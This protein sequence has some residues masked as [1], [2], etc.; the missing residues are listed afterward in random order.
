MARRS[1][2]LWIAVLTV[3][4]ACCCAGAAGAAQF[5][6]IAPALGIP[7]A[8]GAA[9]GDY[10]G[11]GYADLFLTGNLNLGHGAHLLRN[12]GNLSFT[13]VS[14]AVGIPT[15]LMDQISCAWADYDNDG[16]PDIY[17]GSDGPLPDA[18]YHNDGGSFTDVAVQAG[19]TA[20]LVSG[21]AN[22]TAAWCDY[23]GDGQL[24]L[25]ACA[26]DARLLHN[27][28]DG[29]FTDATSSAG[30]TGDAQPA[31]AHSCAWGDYDNDGRPDL[32]VTRPEPWKPL[33]YHNNGDGT[34]TDVGGFLSVVSNG[35]GMAWGD[36]DNDGCLDLY[37]TTGADGATDWLFHNNGDGTF[38]DVAASAGMGAD[39][40]TSDTVTWADY[41]NDGYLDI[42]V[43][44]TQTGGES[45]LY[46]NN[47][48]GTFTNVAHD[49]GM[50]G[51]Y[52]DEAA[53]WADIDHDGRIDLCQAG[54]LIS[55]LFHNIG[56]AGN[57]LRVQALT[58]GS[59]DATGAD[60]VRDAIGAR[61]EVNL[62]DDD[63][64]AAGRILTRLIDGGSG[65][66]GQ[67]EQI[68]Q[69]GLGTSTVVAVRVRFSDGSMVVHRSVPANQ[70]IVVRDVPAGRVEIFDDVPLDYWAYPSIAAA[71]NAHI[72]RGYDDGTYR[73]A[74][75]VDRA[76]MAVYIARALAGG[77]AAVPDPSEDTPTFADAGTD[78]WA[79]KYIEY[80]A[81]PAANVVQGYSDGSYQPEVIVNRGQMAVYIARA[82]VS[83]SGDAAVP[84][85]PADPTFSDVTAE[86][87]WS[88][89]RKHVE[90]LAAEG[91]VQGYSDGTYHPE[92][93]ITR[94]QMAVYIQRA[95][96]LPL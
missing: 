1:P 12:N 10:D 93:A 30:L 75:Q 80:V 43:G 71:V 73:P 49:E 39:V 89:C 40:S 38:T 34:F 47:G 9:W 63:G 20:I 42:Y 33:L 88:W 78:H 17:V 84:D 62:D 41:D 58:S 35:V 3:A 91:I 29:T 48:D 87:D 27:N 56:P 19:I 90:Y 86:N 28:G 54:Q 44:N 23:D 6:D 46:H 77:D 92:V 60:P 66:L 59:G 72:V 36:Y 15:T 85:P 74:G 68:A 16:L 5:Q 26:G 96:D 51:T 32:I 82:V 65:F 25:F 21:N 57:W 45:M 55:R 69:F 2:G 50:A 31:G 37:I 7:G 61:V 83:P 4:L 22:R 81:S 14:D 95:F 67:N 24:D 11:D 52:H 70:Q 13:D 18:L 79:F 94:G 64:F 76:S 8:V 53:A